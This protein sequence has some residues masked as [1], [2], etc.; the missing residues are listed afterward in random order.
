MVIEKK[1]FTTT[2]AWHKK[3]ENGLSTRTIIKQNLPQNRNFYEK[4]KCAHL[5]RRERE[6]RR[7]K[8]SG[9]GW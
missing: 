1:L 6:T 7:V 8:E 5:S 2:T 3:K 9:F 4:K